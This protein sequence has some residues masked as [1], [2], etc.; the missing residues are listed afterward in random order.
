[1]DELEKELATGTETEGMTSSSQGQ[2]KG[3]NQDTK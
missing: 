3:N 2:H 1:M